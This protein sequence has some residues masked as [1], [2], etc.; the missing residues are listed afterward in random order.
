M[1]REINK[2]NKIQIHIQDIIHFFKV[3]KINKHV[4]SISAFRMVI[5]KLNENILKKSICF[6]FQSKPHENI[7][8]LFF[9]SLSKL[10]MLLKICD[11]NDYRLVFMTIHQFSAIG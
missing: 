4:N 10:K 5:I 3:G 9:F 6:C 2:Q 11:K 8:F 1:K 7:I